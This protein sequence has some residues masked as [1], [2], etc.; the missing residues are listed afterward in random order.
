[1][2]QQSIRRYVE[3][4]VS[5]VPTLDSIHTGKGMAA[6]RA[7]IGDSRIVMLGE[8]SHGDGT[9]FVAKSQLVKYL[10]DSLGFDVLA[11][12]SDAF[13]LTSGW[14]AIRK[15]KESIS[16]FI[17]YNIYPVWSF[18]DEC[19]DLL[20]RYLP[21]TY[22]S[23]NPLLIAGID[24]QMHGQFTRDSLL[25][26]LNKF[27][28]LQKDHLPEFRRYQAEC[29]SLLDS[30]LVLNYQSKSYLDSILNSSFERRLASFGL[31]INE[32][33]RKLR[34]QSPADD[35][36]IAIKNLSTFINDLQQRKKKK[37]VDNRDAQMADNLK[38]L[39]YSKFPNSKI[40]VWAANTHIM[41]NASSSFEKAS[42][43]M[44]TLGSSFTADK[45]LSDITY[46]LGFTSSMGK[47]QTVMQRTPYQLNISPDGLESWIP[48]TIDFGFVDFRKFK[49]VQQE[50]KDYFS[51]KARGHS[52][53][54]A[55]WADIFDGIFY[56]RQMHPA[57]PINSK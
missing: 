49:G 9:T 4:N 2:G 56:I 12:E 50:F 22:A 26:R 25:F 41:K 24:P 23:K 47:S 20:Y 57:H 28:E 55:R 6:V 53:I 30:V 36:Y 16:V 13:G 8:Q 42:L 27:F 17:K 5:A 54:N 33:E 48:N 32:I 18:S 37:P 31:T 38:W 11:F 14:S 34:P 39:V 1:M 7:A 15:D 3:L 35:E 29:L 44:S 21:S 45:S 52:A 19:K 51:L 40:I 43:N 10:H 46:I